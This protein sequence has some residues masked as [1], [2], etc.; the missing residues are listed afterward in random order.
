[1][2]GKIATV[3]CAVL[4][5]PEGREYE[6][7]ERRTPARGF[8]GE[9]WCIVFDEA[10]REV[11]K[12]LRTASTLRV[13]LALPDYL[14]WTEYKPLRR[15]TLA[16]VLEIDGAGVSRALHELH[17]RGVLERRGKGPV[18]TWRLSLKWGWRGSAGSYRKAAREAE[19]QRAA[20]LPGNVAVL[21]VKGDRK[22][23]RAKLR[24][25][26]VAPSEAVDV[27]PEGQRSLPLLCPVRSGAG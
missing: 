12:Q 16:E 21:P 3:R 13:F 10:R 27:V 24:L 14:S 6:L 25:A 1:M 26:A 9:R 4:T 19:E 11:Y 18:T 22:R 23:L 20:A 2:A 8:G 17:E 7:R 5:D 15:E